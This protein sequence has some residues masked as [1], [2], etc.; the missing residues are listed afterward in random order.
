MK[1]HFLITLI[2][3]SA[4]LWPVGAAGDN[5]RIEISQACATETGCGP[6]DSPGFP[7]TLAA[8]GGYVLTSDLVPGLDASAIEIRQNSIDLD[9]NGFSLRGPG[10]IGGPASGIISFN[11]FAF[12]S[13]IH[14][15]GIRGFRGVGIDLPG[16]DGVELKE[17]LIY[18]NDE[19]GVVLGNS[20][21]VKETRVRSNGQ[22][23]MTLGPTT[24]YEDCTV[25]ETNQGP[26]VIGGIQIGGSY[27]DDATCTP[28]P[29]MRRYYL[30]PTEVAG[31]QALNACDAGF[32]M[33]SL[34]E[35]W[36]LSTLRYDT[37]RGRTSDDSGEGPPA[38]PQPPFVPR[39]GWIRTGNDAEGVPTAGVGNCFA[40]ATAGSESNGTVA[41]PLGSD[42]NNPAAVSD[43]SPWSV[44]SRPCHLTA[45]VWCIED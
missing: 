17:L 31:N 38:G 44:E 23:G 14:S 11:L 29:P 36:A 16:I 2:G 33:A 15:G 13:R 21:L 8:L 43:V 45:S 28:Y 19:G 34:F 1:R 39:H 22:F 35:V 4:L 6:S 37:T 24:A 3:S 20:G 9:L 18:D 10:L 12:N 26:A 27:C 41:G 42:W 32:H 5:G 30:T 25:T 7:V 40:W